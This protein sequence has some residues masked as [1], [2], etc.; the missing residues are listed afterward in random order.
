MFQT[1]EIIW[2]KDGRG[3]GI[4]KFKNNKKKFD[5]ENVHGDVIKLN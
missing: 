4:H 3:K 2:N 5:V 1:R